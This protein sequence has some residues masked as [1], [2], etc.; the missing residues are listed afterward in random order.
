[1]KKDNSFPFGSVSCPPTVEEVVSA[2][3]DRRNFFL[4]LADRYGS[5]LYVIEEKTLL[6]RAREFNEAFR[7]NLPN[8]QAFFPVKANSHPK[9]L[10]TMI[11]AGLGLEVSSGLELELAVAAGA[12][13]ILFNGPAKSRD[14]LRLALEHRERVI[15]IVDSENELTRLGPLAEE[16]ET[17]IRIGVR[18]ALATQGLWR[19]FGVPIP[20]LTRFIEL[21]RHYRRLSLIGLHFHTSWNMKPAAQVETIRQLGK[22]LRGLGPE[23]KRSFE[24]ID[25]GGG[26]WP[27]RGEWAPASPPT[28]SVHGADASSGHPALLPRSEGPFHTTEA[29]SS[30]EEFARQI[31]DVLGDEVFPYVQCRIFAEPGRWICGDAAHILLTV[32]DRKGDEIAITDGGTNIVGWDQF[33]YEYFPLI[34]LTRPELL[35]R[36]FLV[37][38]SLCTPHDLWGRSYFGRDIQCGDLLMIP[39]QGAYTYSM[40]QHFIKPLPATIFV[41][42]EAEGEGE[43]KTEKVIVA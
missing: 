21:A 32:L 17:E 37:L 22:A 13:S 18:L 6:A 19:K 1:M 39:M 25:I 23:S 14:E 15:V 7:A 3:L 24:F 42:A 40:R 36:P 41:F 43:S 27:H 26:F 20:E 10:E 5:P 31:S 30:I 38:G 9:V 34:N 33:E 29:A 2:Y 4:A 35:E 28:Y 12:R 8:M 16:Q 11:K